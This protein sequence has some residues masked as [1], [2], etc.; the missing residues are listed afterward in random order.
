MSTAGVQ[1]ETR[2]LFKK[3]CLLDKMWVEPRKSNSLL[4]KYRNNFA[5]VKERASF[6]CEI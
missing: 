2:P 4:K 6:F 1:S 3:Y 5:I